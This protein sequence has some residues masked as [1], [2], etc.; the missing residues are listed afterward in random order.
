MKSTKNTTHINQQTTITLTRDNKC[1]HH[2]YF[3]S[4]GAS[5]PETSMS[6]IPDDIAFL[7]SSPSCPKYMLRSVLVHGHVGNNIRMYIYLCS[8]PLQPASNRSSTWNGWNQRWGLE[9]CQKT[10]KWTRKF[11]GVHWT[12]LSILGYTLQAFQKFPNNHNVCKLTISFACYHKHIGNRQISKKNSCNRRSI[13]G[14]NKS[15]NMKATAF[16]CILLH[17]AALQENMNAEHCI[18]DIVNN[19]NL[20]RNIEASLAVSTMRVRIHTAQVW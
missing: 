3:A 4:K 5:V 14:D 2:I 1:W 11:L 13:C 7:E 10:K 16:R 8:I 9:C 20:G 6:N 18:Y 15:G 19:P 12:W 17:H